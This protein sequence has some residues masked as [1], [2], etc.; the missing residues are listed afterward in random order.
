MSQEAIS[1]WT[2]MSSDPEL[3]AGVRAGDT[4][5]FGVLYER[6]VEAARKVASMYSNSATDVDDVVSEA[7][8]RVLRA[9]QRGDGPDLAFRAYLFT[10]V[11]RTGMDVINKGIRTRPRD[12]METFESAIGYETGADEPT[13]DG[14]EHGMVADAF[15]SLPERWQAVLWYTEVE[16]KSP[17][18]IAPLLGLSANGVAALS[19][20]AREA[21][22]QAYLQQHLNTSDEVSCLEANAQL[23]AY[24][25][26]GLNKREATRMSDHIRSC[27]RCAALVAELEDVNRGMRSVIAPL[28][29]GIMGVAALDGGLSIGGALG[30]AKG[31]SSA[32][33]GSSASGAAGTSATSG[34]ASSASATGMAATGATMSGAASAF[35][36][37][38]AG[39][40]VP[41]AAVA[42]VVALGF[43]GAGYLGLLTAN[44][45]QDLA[46]DPIATPSADPSPSVQGE[47]EPADP[48]DDPTPSPSPEAVPTPDPETYLP[49]AAGGSTAPANQG[50]SGG[51]G[52]DGGSGGDGGT[53]GDGGSGGDGGDGG[54]GTVGAKLSIASAPL[55]F[56]EIPRSTPTVPL[57]VSNIGDE[58]SDEVT[59][60]ITLPTGLQFASPPGGSG[61]TSRQAQ[62]LAD[63]MD[64]AL[65][66]TVTVDGWVCTF[67]NAMTTATCANPSIDA[68]ASS[69][70]ALPASVGIGPS[71][72]LADDA[73][74]TYVV[75]TGDEEV[76][77]TVRT[78][79]EANEEDFEDVF[80]GEGKLAALHFGAPLMGCDPAQ[81]VNGITC[82]QAMAFAG[83][84]SESK[85]NNNA[86]RMV[87]L[88][89]AGGE[90]NSATTAITLPP[91]AVV[92]YAAIEWAA[93]R[94]SGDA[95]FDGPTDTA[96][97]R[98]PGG[99][100]VT[101]TADAVTTTID[102]SNRLTYQ[103]TAEITDLVATAGAGNYSVADIAQSID[104]TE[105]GGSD[106]NYFAGFAITIVY[107]L[108]SLPQS[109]IAFFDGSEWVTA[110]NTPDF[111]F[112]T[113]RPSNVTVGLVAW[114][115]DR[116]TVGDQ[117][118]IGNLNGSGQALKPAMWT[119]TGAASNG[120]SGNVGA[121]T[122]FGSIYGN[123][124]GT[125]AKLFDPTNV[126]IGDH[127]LR[128]SGSG[129]NYLLGT[130][131]VTI[132]PHS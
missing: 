23:G 26:G 15:R 103:A 130:V 70:T 120:D 65:F 122:A 54:T 88:N 87:P 86:W 126:G 1:L 119:G 112:H 80:T 95:G 40:A 56:L 106:P 36:S 9:L 90:R 47:D 51:D 31:A 57:N 92:K 41:L 98:V 39:F 44:T 45:P 37:G 16:K 38:I 27:E 21:L 91:G 121:S 94:G 85:Y 102:V 5:A 30:A 25:R 108:D 105:N 97:I 128:F 96:R 13:L 7:F 113:D 59:A 79:L 48:A 18:E 58:D 76:T 111:T 110:S 3:I 74:T 71:Q 68:G 63:Y 132:T 75:S 33:T 11:R 19:Y 131:T 62:Q 67:D 104:L 28:V 49:P 81:T 117:A 109:V 24:V 55:G 125:D 73:V 29:L 8:S 2:E 101:L 52:G 116:G 89:E 35:V 77:Y 100:Y 129:D 14:F 34:A 10:I 69:A 72:Q 61:S 60:S 93:N 64:F 78:A 84:G 12:D 46:L 42:G 114:D 118:Q 17:R 20:R 53:G 83:N 6:H 127:V 124:F 99:E 82:A 107:E 22:R 4:A 50:G 66:G 115:G 123:S 43:A 32:A